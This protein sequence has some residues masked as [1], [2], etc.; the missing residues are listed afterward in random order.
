[1][2]AILPALPSRYGIR[3]F[4]SLNPPRAQ[5]G[6][7]LGATRAGARQSLDRDACADLAAS[8]PAVALA[9]AAPRT[10]EKVTRARPE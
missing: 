5:A 10:I 4:R 3:G 9:L 2:A 1:M 8:E 6:R 7:I